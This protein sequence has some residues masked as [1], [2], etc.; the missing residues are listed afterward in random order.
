M[1]HV[2]LFY[3]SLN[4]VSRAGGGGRGGLVDGSIKQIFTVRGSESAEP[5]G[6]ARCEPAGPGR[7]KRNGTDLSRCWS[8]AKGRRGNGG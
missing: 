7:T 2:N 8:A 1:K 5:S 6:A 4:R 3:S